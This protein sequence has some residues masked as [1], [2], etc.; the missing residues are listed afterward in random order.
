[1]RIKAIMIF[2]LIMAISSCTREKEPGPEK[3]PEP[4]PVK[5]APEKKIYV[6]GV[7]Y[8]NL[9]F[10]YVAALQKAAQ[11]AAE[12]LGVKLIE[13][14]AFNDT[15][16]EL[17]NVERML[18]QKIDCLAFEAASLAATTPPLSARNRSNPESCSGSGSPIFTGGRERTS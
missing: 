3:S 12:K 4:F 6:I 10:P 17:E 9:A 8:Q 13:T 1:M 2:I 18:G 14:D 15:G 7:S 16:K 5:P 11:N